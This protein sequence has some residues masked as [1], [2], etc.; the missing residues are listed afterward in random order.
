MIRDVP[1]D[2]SRWEDINMQIDINGWER[3]NAMMIDEIDTSRVRADEW[4][5]EMTNVKWSYR[6]I[7]WMTD[8]KY[9]KF[10]RKMNDRCKMLRSRDRNM[11]RWKYDSLFC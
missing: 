7:H 10:V 11:L 2:Q 9:D 5:N 6:N 3:M 8:I 4:I 1:I